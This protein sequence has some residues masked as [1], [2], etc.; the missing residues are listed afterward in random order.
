MKCYYNPLDKNCKSVT[1]GVKTYTP[2]TFS[3]F[4]DAERLTLVLHKDGEEKSRYYEMTRQGDKFVYE[5]SFNESG[6]Y[7]YYFSF[8]CKSNIGATD[9]LLGEITPNPRAYQLT[10]FTPYET[11]AWLKGGFIYQIF[12]DRFCKCGNPPVKD[13]RVMHEDWYDC[14][15]YLP[16]ERGEILN[17]DFFGGNFEGVIS[18]LPYLRDLGVTAIYFNPIFEAYSNHRYDTGD[19]M[20]IDSMLGTEED[21]RRLIAEADTYGIKVILDGVFNHTGADSKY[22]NKYGKYGTVGAY[23]SKSSPYAGWYNFIDF[24]T[25][26]ASWWGIN[27]LPDLNESNPSYIKF[28]TGKNGVLDKYTSM[29]VC[30]WRLDVADELPDDFI[31]RIRAAVKKANPSAAVIGEVWEDAS[32][33]IAYGVRRKYFQ[34]KSLDGVMNYP[35]KNAIIEFVTGG[36]AAGLANLVRSQTDHYPKQS[37]DVTM[38]ILGTHDTVRILSALEAAPYTDDKA[39]LAAYKLEGEALENAI[40]R[41]KAAALLQFTFCGVP[42]VYYGD[43]AGMQGFK[44]P[45]NRRGYPWGRENKELLNWYK[46]LGK[47]R[48]LSAFDGGDYEEIYVDKRAIIFRRENVL[49]GVNRGDREYRLDFEGFL[50]EL[51]SGKKLLNRA[52]LKPFSEIVLSTEKL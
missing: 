46:F 28:I 32:D 3:V 49:I 7:W 26:Y 31:Y 45:L 21:F 12:P 23:Q 15:V 20:K 9:C 52:V 25:C 34:G 14:P 17:N 8:G 19:Y 40:K 24:P 11:P 2:V 18:K 29:G 16:N 30:G 37:L 39:V 48:K 6:L 5:L 38:N 44:D 35:L 22:F 42:C 36:D 33:K 10:V 43:E 50:Y 41:L 1:G 13:G 47:L 51:I 27:T 4:T